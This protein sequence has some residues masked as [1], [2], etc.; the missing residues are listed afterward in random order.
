MIHRML[1]DFLVPHKHYEEEVISD[2][3]DE[4]LNE[5]DTDGNPSSKTIKRWKLWILINT[6]DINGLLKS[7]GHRELGFSEELMKSSVSLLKE[8]RRSIPDGWLRT[9]LPVI[10]NTGAY[11]IPFYE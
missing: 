6:L 1:P 4:R 5:D 10:Y 7:I 2:C 11:L 9:I 8:L 3:V